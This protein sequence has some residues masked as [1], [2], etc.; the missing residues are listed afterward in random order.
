MGRLRQQLAKRRGVGVRRVLLEEFVVHQIKLGELFA[1]QLRRQGLDALPEYDRA[2]GGVELR[3]QLLGS[4]Q[5][6]KRHA[7]PHTAALLHYDQDAHMTR[8]SNRSFSTSWAAAA[9][10][11]PSKIWVRLTRWGRY[12]R[13]R[14]MAAAPSLPPP[15]SAGVRRL[16][17]FVLARLMPIRVA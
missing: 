7:V 6:F 17:S 12:T 5:G 3:G 15:S 1:G 4:G 8:A 11:F 10:G 9:C 2:G 13:S 14:W 16:T